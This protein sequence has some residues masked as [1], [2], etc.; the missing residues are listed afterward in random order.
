MTAALLLVAALACLHAFL[1]GRG[2]ARIG[3]RFARRGVRHLL[4]FALPALAGLAAL[5][6][7]DALAA[8]PPEFLP[9]R[10]ALATL[11]GGTLAPAELARVTGIG[12]LLGGI[13]VALVERRRRRPAGL[14]DVEAVM[15]RTRAEL[16]WAAALSLSAGIGE[17]LFFRLLLPLL[18]AIVTGSATAGF[19]VA[20][21]LF[22]WAHRYQGR[23]GIAA[24]M[25]S[26]ALL[27][28]AYLLTAAFWV[29]IALHIA[30]D[31]NALVLRPVLSGRIRR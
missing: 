22:G 14:G 9:A 5:G 3:H 13:F 17:E 20:T 28:A 11:V 15:P 30:I 29:A 2:G 4:W 16:P 24:T 18:T 27:A 1:T 10:I 12:V 25:V 7:L 6:R 21:V 8:M 23:V 31:L 26:G 19:V